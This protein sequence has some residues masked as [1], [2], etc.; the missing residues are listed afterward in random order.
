MGSDP[1]PPAWHDGER[2]ARALRFEL[3]LGYAPI[4]IYDVIARRGV[5]LAFRDLGGDD[6]R[7]VFRWKGRVN[8]EQCRVVGSTLRRAIASTVPGDEQ[9]AC[10]YACG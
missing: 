8:S 9:H 7:Y 6:G 4:D 3:G 2:A 1:R 10:V 5:A